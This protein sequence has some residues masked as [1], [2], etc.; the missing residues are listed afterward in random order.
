M[1]AHVF[2]ISMLTRIVVTYAV[3][4]LGCFFTGKTLPTVGVVLCHLLRGL[5]LSSCR[6]Y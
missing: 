2:V 1:K 5:L 4:L 3:L 6:G